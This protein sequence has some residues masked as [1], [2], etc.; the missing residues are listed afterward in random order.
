[1]ADENSVP[2][3]PASD[4]RAA[5]LN[6][7]FDEAY[8]HLA[9]AH[10]ELAQDS[11]KEL[12][13]ALPDHPLVKHLARQS[14]LI[15][16]RWPLERRALHLTAR[17][18]RPTQEID[19][20]AFHVDLPLVPS[21]VHQVIDY[22]TVL[23][24]SFESARLKAPGA[25]RVLLTDETTHVPDSI[26]AD[27]VMRFPLN[28]ELVMY[29]RMRIQA[30]YL[31]QREAGRASV[32]MDSDVVVN[33]DPA[34][35]F[36]EAFDVGLTWRLGSP[37]APFNGGMI[38]V[39]PG[40]AGLAFFRMARECY[41]AIAVDSAITSFFPKDL[42]AWWGDQ[43]A[44]ASMVGYDAYADE[45]ERNLSVKGL[46]AMLEQEHALPCTEQELALGARYR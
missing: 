2:Q 21:G 16:F 43:Y 36:A 7:L 40:E 3:A 8:G 29:E 26:P 31:E 25:R 1:M 37:E 4:P 45:M 10:P 42:R 11:I 39:A 27:L 38:L 28:R 14:T 41:D 44:L 46:T 6:S 18:P 19:L 5:R 32:L 20:V 13:Q 15:A 22:T 34:P 30:L 24:R 35:I 17:E 23:A 9:R 33:R 12:V